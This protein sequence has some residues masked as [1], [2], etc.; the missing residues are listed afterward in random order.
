ML[1]SIKTIVNV[2]D[3]MADFLKSN[4]APEGTS[5]APSVLSPQRTAALGASLPL[6]RSPRLAVSP[7]KSAGVLESLPTS[8]RKT[9]LSSAS[10]A[11]AVKLVG[12][13]PVPTHSPKK[14][15][16]VCTPPLSVDTST[17]AVPTGLKSCLS[18]RKPRKSEIMSVS[19]RKSVVFGSPNAVEFDKR[20]PTTKFTPMNRMETRSHFSMPVV[21]AGCDNTSTAAPL[22]GES[23]PVDEVTEENSRI[24][25]EWDRLTNTSCS[26][27][28]GLPD[29]YDT[30]DA[31]FSSPVATKR[32]SKS[33]KRRRTSSSS[34]Y[35]SGDSLGVSDVSETELSS[36]MNI[37][38]ESSPTRSTPSRSPISPRSVRRRKSKVFELETMA[39]SLMEEVDMQSTNDS[40]E[41]VNALDDS[42]IT[43][44]STATSASGNDE[45]KTMELPANLGE[46][47]EQCLGGKDTPSTSA[48][49][50]LSDSETDL[51]SLIHLTGNN[52][53]LVGVS[54]CSE[55]Q[56][57]TVALEDNLQALLQ[58]GTYGKT[59]VD[60]SMMSVESAEEDSECVV[61]ISMY[62]AQ[63]Q[64]S[65]DISEESNG[66]SLHDIS[67][68][69]SMVSAIDVNDSTIS[70]SPAP[71]ATRGQSELS[72]QSTG[73]V[74]SNKEVSTANSMMNGSL[75]YVEDDATGTVQLPGNLME[76][77]DEVVNSK[78]ANPAVPVQGQSNISVASEDT[79]GSELQEISPNVSQCTDESVQSAFSVNA[80]EMSVSAPS[81]S[82]TS[83]ISTKSNTSGYL[84]T[85]ISMLDKEKSVLNDES[86][87]I[88]QEES[89]MEVE[90][91]QNAES[92]ASQTAGEVASVVTMKDKFANILQQCIGNDIEREQRRKKE[93][94]DNDTMLYNAHIENLRRQQE[95]LVSKI[96]VARIGL[97]DSKKLC[98]QLQDEVSKEMDKK[99]LAMKEAIQQKKA[100]L[101]GENFF[102]STR[103]MEVANLQSEIGKVLQ[104]IEIINKFTW[105]KVTCYTSSNVNIEVIL[106]A[107]VRAAVSF[108][109]TKTAGVN[110]PSVLEISHSS[111]EL[112]RKGSDHE[113][114]SVES[115]R[116]IQFFAHDLCS[117]AKNGP[118]SGT[119]LANLYNPCEL[120][121]LLSLVCYLFIF[122]NCF[123]IPYS[124]F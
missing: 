124:C 99:S 65:M 59:S 122:P 45:T 50:S 110:A 32:K 60:V 98:N 37:S 61:D 66:Q 119:Y 51:S 95:E 121:K 16:K 113:C 34:T 102:K 111:V 117:D 94:E 53:A 3:V 71:P 107:H 118:L 56:D 40:M 120:P 57:H 18:S 69:E 7:L 104:S 19:A 79:A 72:F 48:N 27:P 82:G 22:E 116:A 54:L 87:V 103:D 96:E 2:P 78:G 24:L 108:T 9:G 35:A 14:T 20:K 38:R 83:F 85:D 88:P 47:M 43:N 63:G 36:V 33:P 1:N 21:M 112:V 100:N 15:I 42:V 73:S 81:S 86:V 39:S 93:K 13:S 58:V 44:V 84:S 75:V 64:E 26:P 6:R 109:L 10:K 55:D 62:G 31:S 41:V 89:M 52:S 74:A 12:L 106:S 30:F 105:C 115:Q 114:S 29:E 25:E 77:M 91:E 101:E 67:R 11:A 76:L 17:T 49:N 80:G 4:A 70:L 23:E 97:E 92:D 123:L 46:L 28:S 8:R 90:E 5:T 68:R